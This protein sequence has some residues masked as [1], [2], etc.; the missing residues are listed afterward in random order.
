MKKFRTEILICALSAAAAA[1]FILTTFLVGQWQLALAEL[2]AALVVTAVS[3][4]LAHRLKSRV[5]SSVKRLNNALD[6][7]QRESVERFPLPVLTADAAGR[8]VWYNDLFRARV[9]GDQE[10]E[11]EDVHAFIGD[12]TLQELADVGSTPTVYG[13]RMYTVYAGA[14]GRS[15]SGGVPVYMLL[16]VDD[17]SLKQVAEEYEGMHPAVMYIAADNLLEATQNLRDSERAAVTGGVEKIIE[18]WMSEYPAFMCRLGDARFVAVTEDRQLNRMI[19]DKFSVLTNM[20][21]FSYAGVK[22]LTLSIG[23]GRGDSVKESG[24]KAKQALDMALGRG[25]DQ[26]AIKQ[27]DAYEFFGGVSMGV[28]KGTKVHTR[29]TATAIEELIEGSENVLIMGHRFADLDAL[30]AAIGMYSEAIAQKKEAYIVMSRHKTLTMPLVKRMDEQGRGG[31]L[32][33]PEQALRILTKKSLLIIVD[34]HR[35]DFVES[36]ELY[37]AAKAVIVIDHHRKVVDHIENALIFFHEPGASSASEMVTELLQYMGQRGNKPVVGKFEAEALLAGIMLDTRNFIMR[38]GVRTFEAAAYLKSCGADIISVKQLFTDDIED[39]KMRNTIVSGA[40][41]YRECAI[42]IADIVDNDI[43]VISSQA[44]DEMLNI[45]GV[46]ASF[47]LYASDGLVNISARSM[48]K[49]NVQLI[50]EALG[51]GGHQTMAAAQLDDISLTDAKVRLL[52]EIDKYYASLGD[53][54]TED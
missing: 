40:D 12:V 27:R 4:V 15:R 20:R 37:R 7:T 1:I 13:D 2:A 14:L 11:D 9:M 49:I 24:D 26:A 8:V 52:S 36:P 25:G 44:A 29:I 34:T 54:Q 50:M 31:M 32:I 41:V 22:G 23:V 16:F 53:V 33:E 45:T 30:G 17:T 3:L 18:N 28:E 47:V 43:R 48:G 39:Y 38:T 6:L 46:K 35:P 42:A 21:R 10:L 5:D 19:D 51:G